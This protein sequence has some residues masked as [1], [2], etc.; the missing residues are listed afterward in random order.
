MGRVGRR[1][2]GLGGHG[3]LVTD[4]THTLE[5]EFRTP[6]R[7]RAHV[8]ERI[9]GHGLDLVDDLQARGKPSEVLEDLLLDLHAS[10]RDHRSFESWCRQDLPLALDTVRSDLKPTLWA[11]K[12]L[13][14]SVRED[15]PF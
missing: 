11:W 3:A 13:V 7:V 14:D 6:D 1:P 9:L 8:V 12:Q 2:I 15:P 4:A 10:S 5:D